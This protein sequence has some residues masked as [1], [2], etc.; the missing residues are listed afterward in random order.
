[1]PET[2]PYLTVKLLTEYEYSDFKMFYHITAVNDV[3]VNNS[4]AEKKSKVES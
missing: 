2:Y 3:R 4:Q 1:M